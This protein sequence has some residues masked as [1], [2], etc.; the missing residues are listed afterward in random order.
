MQTI[1]TDNPGVC[2]SITRVGCAKMAEQIAVHSETPETSYSIG[3]PTAHG[4][5]GLGLMQPLPDYFG[6]LL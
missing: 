6:H 5:G 2:L 3:V 1:A 4:D